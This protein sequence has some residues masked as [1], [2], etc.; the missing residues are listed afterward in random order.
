[1]RDEVLFSCNWDFQNPLKFSESSE[2]FSF[3]QNSEIFK[4]A[5][6]NTELLPSTY[7]PN[8]P[9]AVIMQMELGSLYSM[10]LR[11]HIE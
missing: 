5:E 2:I 1:M 7:I 9:R 4:F 6:G 3:L 10:Q 11:E 8:L